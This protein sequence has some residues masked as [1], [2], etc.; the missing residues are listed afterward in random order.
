MQTILVIPFP[1]WGP[2]NAS[3]KLFKGLREKGYEVVYV[4]PA[5]F[6]SFLCN[7]Q[8]SVQTYDKPRLQKSK[9][10][11]KKIKAFYS[12]MRMQDHILE[13]YASKL[14]TLLKPCAIFVDSDL[15]RYAAVLKTKAKV[16]MYS[17]T[18]ANSREK[19]MPPYFSK[20]IP[21][22]SVFS[23]WYVSAIWQWWFFR[24][25]IYFLKY[26][27]LSLGHF[28]FNLKRYYRKN[29][30]SRRAVEWQRAWPAGFSDLPEL[31]LYPR[32][33]DF[34]RSQSLPNKFYIGPMVDLDRDQDQ[35]FE[36]EKIEKRNFLVCC[37]MGTLARRHYPHIGRFYEVLLQAVKNI[38]QVTL[39]LS[40]AENDWKPATPLPENVYLFSKLPLLHV[41]R[42]CDLFINHAGTNSVKEAVL[43]GVPMLLL[44]LNNQTDQNGVAARCVYHGI[45]R[46]KNIRNISAP[47]L[48]AAIQELLVNDIYRK[49]ML[50][51]K[52]SFTEPGSAA[53]QILE[54]LVPANEI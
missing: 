2:V 48:E 54:R 4:V 36:W 1:Y 5:E 27:L 11:Y 33:F 26:E 40:C 49:N 34:G 37:S 43:C 10:F 35:Q 46:R 44:P 24:K 6:E 28:D 18:L 8:F 29:G 41:L 52:K 38:K 50:R 9:S 20:Y 13:T 23:A 16:I 45:A 17:T 39:L 14:L 15:P 53:G 7:Q 25:K 31:M 3:L 22:P 21:G 19:N 51:L 12:A 47:A 32:I 30:L 42:R